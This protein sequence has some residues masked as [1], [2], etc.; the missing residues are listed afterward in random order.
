MGKTG[1]DYLGKQNTSMSGEP[2]LHWSRFHFLTKQGIIGPEEENFCRY[3]A[4]NSDL[5]GEERV[6]PFCLVEDDF[7]SYRAE[8]CDI[9]YCG[10]VTSV[11]I[12]LYFKR[13]TCKSQMHKF[14]DS[15]PV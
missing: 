7:G 14:I 12:N 6:A 9:K 4:V 8:G 11:Y 13:R 15:S 3:P 5:L 2:C 1:S 10:M